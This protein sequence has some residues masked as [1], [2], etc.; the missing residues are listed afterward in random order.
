MTVAFETLGAVTA[1]SDTTGIAASANSETAWTELSAST[2]NAAKV[3]YV[4]VHKDGIAN[5]ASILIDVGVGSAGSEVV[6]V[7]DLFLEPGPTGSQTWGTFF[8]PYTVDIATSSRIAARIE[9]SNNADD[10]Q[11]Q[12]II[13]SESVPQITSPSTTS[14]GTTTGS[15]PKGT[16]VDPGASANTKGAW[17][18]LTTSFSSTG[19]HVWFHIGNNQN[20]VMTDCSWLI[21][22]GTGSDG[23]EVAV[24]ENIHVMCE[25][26]GDTLG[27]RM[28]GPFPANVFQSQRVAARAQCSI[29][30]STDRLINMTATAASGTVVTG[31]G[32]GG[33]VQLVNSNALVS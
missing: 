4:N 26:N 14:Y 8:G 31:G 11:I 16:Q 22:I 32:G 19:E 30:D 18:E 27:P 1:S 33:S 13:G 5:T 23:S 7:P 3:L 12:V 28:V 6:T 29:T 21:D 9:G 10:I 17:S 15:S 20:S 25:Q 24:I 2:A